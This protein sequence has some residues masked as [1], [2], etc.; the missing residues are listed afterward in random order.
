LHIWSTKIY[1]GLCLYRTGRSTEA[2]DVIKSGIEKL[3][4]AGE[5]KA[6]AFAYKS[7]SEVY[8]NLEDFENAFAALKKANEVDELVKDNKI[9]Y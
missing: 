7:L 4:I 8:S 5:S 2:I 9:Y 1:E 3:E 6:L